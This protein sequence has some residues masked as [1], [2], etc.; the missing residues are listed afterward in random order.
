MRASV[1]ALH[2]I[3]ALPLDPHFPLFQ[4]YP[5]MK[6]GVRESVRFYARLLAPLAEK[7]MAGEPD[8]TE[9]VM[10]APPLYAIP[11]GANLVAR[12]VYRILGELT[13]R[14]V[15]LQYVDL[16]YALPDP[17]A[18]HDPLR[19]G[20]YSNSGVAARI[21][22]RRQ[23]HEGKWAP[24]PDPADFRDRAVLVIN[25]INVTGTQQDFIERTLGTVH[26]ASIHWLYVLQVDPPLG[27]TSPEVEYALNHL[28]LETFEE[29]AA[30]VAGADIDYTSRCVA[31]LFGDSR[32]RLVPLLRSLDETR[33]R[34][35]HQ[36]VTEEGS[37]TAEASE[38]KL[39]QLH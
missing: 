34:R 31:R 32:D 3:T 12:E 8:T 17:R 5:A 22:N 16:R 23:L 20:D 21:E 25:D 2:T 7:I 30:I 27:R 15:R 18:A 26:P 29:F 28:N 14:H 19:A 9:W 39:A 6:L 33:R 37:Y 36:L 1:V 11:A 35:L 4:Q 38:A 10:T 24:R 13:P